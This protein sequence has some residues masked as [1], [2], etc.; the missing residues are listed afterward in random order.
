MKLLL[1]DAYAFIYRAYYAFIKSPRINSKGFNTSAVLGFVN[2][3][4]D[5]LRREEPTHIAVAFDPGGATFRHE[6][7]DSYKA[8]RDETPEVIRLSVPIIK[9]ILRAYRIPIVLKEGFEADDVIGTLAMRGAEAGLE[10]LMMTPDKDFAQLVQEHVML[11][12]PRFGSSEYDRLGVEEIKTKYQIE[13]PRQMID[14]LAIMGDSADNIPGCPGI[15]EKGA[16]KLIAAYGSVE[17]IIAHTAELKGAT[18]SKVEKHAALM[19]L[20]KQLA[21]IHVEVPLGDFDPDD[22]L[23]QPADEETLR[24]LYDELEFR[25]FAKRT[26]APSRRPTS[27]PSPT[28]PT[29]TPSLFDAVAPSS[30]VAP[31]SEPSLFAENQGAGTD[32][33]LFSSLRR[34]NEAQIDYYHADTP[35]VISQFVTKALASHLVS[36]DTET[37]SLDPLTCR[38]VGVSLSYSLHEALF[39]PMPEDESLRGKVL[40][41]LAPLW[42]DE[43]VTLVGHNLKFDLM[44]LASLGIA[45]R[46]K[47]YDT[48]IAH[49]LLAPDA[50]HSMDLLA[51]Q[52]LAYEPIHIE[53]LIGAKGKDQRTMDQ[54][55][56]DQLTQYAAEDADITLQLYH[57]FAPM[58]EAKGLG[59]VMQRI[60][61][62]L[63]PIL[64]EMERTGVTL[65]TEALTLSA[66]RIRDR[67]QELETT[68]YEAGG[69]EINI[70][71]AKQ[72][73]ELLFDHLKVVDK[74]KKTK[75]GQYSTS[76]EVLIKL[77]PAHPIVAQILEYRGLKKLLSTYIDALPQLIHPATGRIHTSF[78]QAV[79]ATGRLS[80]SNPNLQ[81]IPIRE[82]QGRELRR[83][84]STPSDDLLFVSADYSQIEL[85]LMAHL[86]QDPHMLEAFRLEMDIHTATAAKIYH[87][88]PDEV[89]SEMRRKAKTAN[90]GIIYGISTF[91]L[92]E[93]LNIPRK[94]AAQLIEG[95]FETYPGVKAYMDRSIAEAKETGEVTT[96]L[97]RRRRLPDI[98][99]GNAVVRGYAERNAINAP[100]Q[101]TAADIIKLAMIDIARRLHLGGYAAKMVLQVH[102]ELN[103]EVP[104]EELDDV[105]ALIVDAMEHVLALSVP[106]LVE[107]GTGANWLEAH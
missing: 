11:Y 94:E 100:I 9:D 59:E 91:G 26:L 73:G 77:A 102:D 62:P 79:T 39:V 8:N 69:R 80:S 14:L 44:V 22:Y 106:L 96:L 5:V 33:T 23:V 54:V 18:K 85:R 56:L 76:E 64:A 55:P 60:E 86:S 46:G 41:A 4:Q 65:D 10:V 83:A 53:E 57:L 61:M 66:D 35:L 98:N 15:G 87:V 71:S 29:P 67:L 27:T 21:T 1:I 49:Y 95:Y 107:C 90:F 75:G 89:T 45:P 47:L 3:L 63:V 17:E 34:L 28:P 43:A 37:T 74:P 20:S 84:F 58:I 72:V 6:M 82:E 103:F 30:A 99:S 13:E 105:R 88:D 25:N 93:R 50:R 51:E 52:Y 12:R 2:T 7:M 24:S 101:G 19:T 97:G 70:N 36:F 68:I 16:Q 42:A 32:A 81:N 40:D 78:N 38:L 31:R 104:R 92:S 48:M